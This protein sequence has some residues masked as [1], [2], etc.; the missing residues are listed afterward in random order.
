MYKFDTGGYTGEWGSEGKIAMLHEKE[1]VL[2]KEDTENLLEAIRLLKGV[3]GESSEKV[4]P[5]MLVNLLVQS[6]GELTEL[7]EKEILSLNQEMNDIASKAV[8]GTQ[9]GYE[10]LSNACGNSLMKLNDKMVGDLGYMQDLH[11]NISDA[12]NNSLKDMGSKVSTN[13]KEKNKE[14]NNTLDTYTK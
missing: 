2:N 11:N 1:L 5:E 10:E 14:Y 13:L 6:H 8:V 4:D 12:Y 9:A 3:S 7:Y